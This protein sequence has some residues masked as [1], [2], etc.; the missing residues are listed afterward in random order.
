MGLKREKVQASMEPAWDCD[1]R[2]TLMLL[3]PN[4]KVLL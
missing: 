2:Q 1:Q 4:L 3:I